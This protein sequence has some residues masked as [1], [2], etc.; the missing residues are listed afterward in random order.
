MTDEAL[1]RRLTTHGRIAYAAERL[2][3][4]PGRSPKKVAE[5]L[6]RRLPGLEI[7]ESVLED[8]VFDA[9]RRFAR[10]A[11]GIRSTSFASTG[12]TAGST[13]AIQT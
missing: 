11:A 8:F 10:P 5:M 7:R 9:L 4:A 3:R 6:E 12:D 2:G 13:T 1:R